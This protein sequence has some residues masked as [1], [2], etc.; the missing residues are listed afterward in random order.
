MPK[1]EIRFGC[2]ASVEAGYFNVES[3]PTE[4][5]ERILIQAEIGGP[6]IY[7]SGRSLRQIAN[8]LGEISEQVYGL[9]REAGE[10]ID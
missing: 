6:T 9:A 7:V 3:I 5:K 4:T 2:Y 8:C 1:G 10:N